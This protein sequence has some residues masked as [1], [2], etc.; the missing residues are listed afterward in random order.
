MVGPAPPRKFAPPFAAPSPRQPSPAAPMPQGRAVARRADSSACG[1]QVAQPRMSGHQASSVDGHFIR[2]APLAALPLCR[3]SAPRRSSSSRSPHS[4]SS[5][6]I[7][8]KRTLCYVRRSPGD[9]PCGG[10]LWRMLSSST[11]VGSR[12]PVSREQLAEFISVRFAVDPDLFDVYSF[13]PE[14]FS[15][16][17]L[18]HPLIG[19]APL[20]TRPTT[21]L[22]APSFK[23]TFKPWSRLAHA[24]ASTCHYRAV[25]DP[26]RHATE[27]GLPWHGKLHSRALLCL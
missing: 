19:T 4:L 24:G 25:L 8:R 26:H 2:A 5:C 11:I 12:P 1:G 16:A 21:V 7:V 27:C 13:A 6:G 17:L 20:A 23:C 18:Q 22:C 9:H 14:D 10:A 3:P 15:R